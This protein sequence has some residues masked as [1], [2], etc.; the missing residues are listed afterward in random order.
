MTIMPTYFKANVLRCPKCG[1]GCWSW[2]PEM[3]TNSDDFL[4]PT[5]CPACDFNLERGVV[6][7][8]AFAE[9]ADW[10]NT[11]NTEIVFG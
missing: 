8:A 5:D 3:G 1:C 6:W 10:I 2:E 4:P 9:L 7:E 11:T